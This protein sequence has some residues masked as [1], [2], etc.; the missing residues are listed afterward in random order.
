MSR[1][2]A[3]AIV[4]GT[5]AVALLLLAWIGGARAT[6]NDD[7]S[8]SEDSATRAPATPA[9]DGVT[10]HVGL[11]VSDPCLKVQGR[12]VAAGPVV[13]RSCRCTGKVVWLDGRGAAEIAVDLGVLEDGTRRKLAEA[14][15]DREGRFDVDVPIPDESLAGG[16]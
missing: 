9:P 3:L 15:T 16:E 1:K 10:L 12:S 2:L 6:T 5:C 7:V 14:R 13:G 11:D 4:L 8:S